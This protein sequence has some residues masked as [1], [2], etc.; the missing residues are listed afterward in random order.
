MFG[1]WSLGKKVGAGFGTILTLLCV[2][3][4]WSLFGIS[5]IVDNAEEVIEGN[6]LAGRVL[7]LEIGHLNWANKVGELIT[8]DEINELTVKTDPTKCK[9]G[10]WLSGEERQHDEHL[11]PGLDAIL[12]RIEAP[13]RHLHETAVEILGHYNP[14][15]MQMASFLQD[16][17][18]AHM[19][20]SA[21]I[22]NAF[23]DP[24]VED[25]QGIQQDPHK[26]S[27]G[28]WLYS[29]E[30]GQKK[31]GNPEFASVWEKIEKDHSVLHSSAKSID[32][33]MRMDEES[34]GLAFFMDTT[35]PAAKKVLAG[36]DEVIVLNE[37]EVA[38]LL[39]AQAIFAEKTLPLLNEVR[40]QLNKA[41]QLVSSNVMTDKEMLQQAQ[42]T[43]QAVTILSII[44][45]IL[46]I[47]LGIIITRSIVLAL[48]R[49]M[50]DLGKGSEQVSAAS[51]QVAEASQ[52]M[53]E[54]ASTQASSLE[55]T[56]ATL[57]E[58]AAMTKENSRSANEANELS[59]SLQ[60][61]AETGQEAMGR[62]TQ[63]IEKIKDSS[64][65]TARIIKTIDEIA[66]Q[67]NL[68]ALNAAVEAARAGDAGKGFAV[69]AEEVRNLAKR[70][71]DSAKDTSELIAQ[72]QINANGGV[73]VTKEVTAILSEVVTGVSRVSD[74]I[75]SVS[76]SNEEQS[77]SV[78]EINKAV[79]QL[80]QV[81]QSNAANAEETASAS[82]E[83]S[84][85]ARE[86]SGMVQT[87]GSI[88]KGGSAEFS[89]VDPAPT[90]RKHTPSAPMAAPAA[91]AP[92]EVANIPSGVIPLT[93]EEMVEL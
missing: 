70:S 64:D 35:A 71:A 54:G 18:I 80:D 82:E 28:T 88:I 8:N 32:A 29:K 77:R 41:N 58:M 17:K 72:S 12:T 25:L 92:A 69:V 86:L 21:S 51:G 31:A 78:T 49:V 36:I 59:D 66:F 67:T 48:I 2:V 81:T 52:D 30:V 56:S 90:A 42:H 9:L 61:V 38:G 47:G 46:G 76:T 10:L 1:N 16:A 44:A 3:G 20:W 93:E 63:A 11:V 19:A 7:E 57:E 33:M 43:K 87:L 5:G 85:Q 37:K 60:T 53:A 79:G 50:D 26:C 24:Y 89:P 34:E 22:S 23:L 73:D 45:V 83:L 75:D 65:Q 40:G 4:V 74:L 68:L 39:A 84:G 91:W 27:F 13:H 55:E 6:Q 14:A 15:D 62:M